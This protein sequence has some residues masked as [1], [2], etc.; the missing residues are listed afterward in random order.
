[1]SGGAVRGAAQVGML[2]EVLSA[3]IFPNA[4]VAVSAGA[5]NGLPIAND[6]SMGQVDLL[7]EIWREVATDP[8]VR[9]GTLRT[10]VSILRGRPGLDSGERLRK[11]L[12]EHV[13]VADLGDTLIPIHVGTT[14]A[15]TGRLCWWSEGPSVDVLCA[16]AAIPGVF[17]AVPL[18][19]GDLHLDGGVLSNVPLRHAVTLQPSRLV[20]FD[21]AADFLSPERQTA[22]TLMLTGFRAATAELT[23]QEWLDVPPDI[24]VLHIELRDPG[25]GLDLDFG[26]TDLLLEEGAGAARAAIAAN[27]WLNPG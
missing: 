7:E 8:P 27:D 24:E 11:L 23:R 6:P 5:L 12:E 25:G 14:A 16:S 2:R 10:L 22:L 21:V 4:V 9:G 3:G 26:E 19:D 13:P 1:M 20:V 18:T 17:P 15:S